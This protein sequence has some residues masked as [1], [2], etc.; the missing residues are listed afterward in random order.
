MASIRKSVKWAAG[1]LRVFGARVGSK[2]QME[3]ADGKPL[4]LGKGARFSV[5]EGAT[6]RVGSGVYLS[7]GCVMEVLPG[8]SLVL[9]DDIY[10]NEGCRV[11]AA[12]SVEIGSGTIFGPDVKVYDHD[13]VFDA[14]GVHAELVTS[15]VSIGGEVLVL[16]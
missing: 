16:C 14:D 5:A 15:P 11:V 9:G 2:G 6:C 12:E 1:M 10:M 7:P 8:A 13:H 4:Y 3:I